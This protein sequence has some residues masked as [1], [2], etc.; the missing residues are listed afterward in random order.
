MKFVNKKN[1][2]NAIFLLKNKFS[3]IYL[4][5]DLFTTM[6]KSVWLCNFHNLNFLMDSFHMA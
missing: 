5:V 2:S 6:L 4:F 3:F 1:E